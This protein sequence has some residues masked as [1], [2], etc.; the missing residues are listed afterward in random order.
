MICIATQQFCNFTVNN[1]VL[2]PSGVP[3]PGSSTQNYY[4]YYSCQSVCNTNFKVL[5]NGT[6]ASPSYCG[7]DG[8]TQNHVAAKQTVDGHVQYI[9]RCADDLCNS[10]GN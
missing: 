3:L 4:P 8:F 7:T 10:S 6:C 2:Q 5:A 9:Y 1:M